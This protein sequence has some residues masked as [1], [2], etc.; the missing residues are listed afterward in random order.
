MKS[1]FLIVA[2]MSSSFLASSAFADEEYMEVTAPNECCQTPMP[3]GLGLIM[4]MGG[5]AAASAASGGLKQAAVDVAMKKAIKEK[6]KKQEKKEEQKNAYE[7]ATTSEGGALEALINQIGALFMQAT[8]N[9]GKTTLKYEGPN[10]EKL[11]FE[12]CVPSGPLNPNKVTCTEQKFE[13][14]VDPTDGME[15]WA[16]SISVVEPKYNPKHYD[17]DASGYYPAV[18]GGQTFSI[19]VE[20]KDDLLWQLRRVAAAK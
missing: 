3:A 2:L 6:S 17:A 5:S 13:I 18:V 9:G 7:K 20:S 10:G 8:D 16:F 11:E 19:V 14:F 12:D 4:S 1:N 15:K